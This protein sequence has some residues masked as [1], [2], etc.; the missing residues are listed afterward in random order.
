MVTQKRKLDDPPWMQQGKFHRGDAL[1]WS[2]EDTE[3]FSWWEGWVGHLMQKEQPAPR[4]GGLT[5]VHLKT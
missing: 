5:M 4:C 2:Y 3:E 1:H